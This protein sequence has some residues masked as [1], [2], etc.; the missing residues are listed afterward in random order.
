M[1]NT[2]EAL[3]YGNICPYEEI[4]R[5]NTEVKE[6]MGLIVRNREVLSATLSEKQKE[7]LEKYDDCN[8][9]MIALCN[10]DIFIEG[11][12]LGMRM[13]VEGL[14]DADGKR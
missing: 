5:D 12:R 10:R 6:L 3:W 1:N 9:E 2:L 14:T 4:G 11:F 7:M 13:T 8:N